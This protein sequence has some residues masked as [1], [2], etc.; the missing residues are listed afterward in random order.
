MRVPAELAAQV[1]GNVAGHTVTPR[2]KKIALAVAAVADL[3][4]LGLFPFFAEGALSIPD[5]VL[6]LVVAVVLFATLGFKL[7]ILLAL[8]VEL[9]PGVALF[10]SWTAVVATIPSAPAPSKALPVSS[11]PAPTRPAPLPE[12]APGKMPETDS[13]AP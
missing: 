11:T 1:H 2:R 9:V 5:D 3:I 8:A 4:Q 12:T 7:R 13:Y 6:D 10:P